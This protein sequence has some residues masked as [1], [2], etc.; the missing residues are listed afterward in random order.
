MLYIIFTQQL[1]QKYTVGAIFDDDNNNNSRMKQQQG[2]IAS[3]N[4]VSKQQS[5]KSNR[6]IAGTQQLVTRR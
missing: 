2:W 4:K 6:A 3:Y 1:S 5:N